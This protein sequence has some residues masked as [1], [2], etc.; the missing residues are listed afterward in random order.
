[1]FTRVSER[2]VS[3]M[4]DLAKL[5]SE[6]DSIVGAGR[7]LGLKQSYTDQLWQRIRR[8]LGEQAV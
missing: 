2:T 4:D 3:L 8:G 7:K 5:V 6:G 1:M